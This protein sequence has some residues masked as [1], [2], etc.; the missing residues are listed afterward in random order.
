VT[1]MH[2]DEKY[3]AG[4]YPNQNF[5]AG[6]LPA[7]MANNENIENKDLVVWYVSGYHHVPRQ[8]DFPIMPNHYMSFT[9]SPNNFFERNPSVDLDS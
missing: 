9:L 3:G 8:E 1:P 5:D 6:G 2:D 4:W 7:Y